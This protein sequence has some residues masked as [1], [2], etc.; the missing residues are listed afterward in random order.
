M[1]NLLQ[2]NVTVKNYLIISVN[3]LYVLVLNYN[4]SVPQKINIPSAPR[5]PEGWEQLAY[6]KGSIILILRF[7]FTLSY[8]L[9]GYQV[10]NHHHL[11]KLNDSLFKILVTYYRKQVHILLNNF[12]QQICWFVFLLV[13]HSKSFI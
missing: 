1:D 11:L 4:S 6:G 2:E 12:L 9:A 3:L 13:V 5:A 8:R 7:T 10:I